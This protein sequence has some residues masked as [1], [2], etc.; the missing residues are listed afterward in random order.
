MNINIDTAS[1]QRE[2]VEKQN[3]Q[4]E[5]KTFFVFCDLCS[6]NEESTRAN[7][8]NSGWHWNDQHAFCPTHAREI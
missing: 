5:P 1:K 4:V 7:L 3:K 8:I 6:D 2:F